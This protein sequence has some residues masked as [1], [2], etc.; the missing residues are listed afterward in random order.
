MRYTLLAITLLIT[1][2]ANKCSNKEGSTGDMADLKGMKWVF[3]RVG[4]QDVSVPAG[5]DAPWVQ[6]TPEGLSGFGG[7][8]R[9]MGGYQQEGERLK[10]T[11]L[12]STKRYCEATMDLENA[13]KGALDRTDSFRMKKDVLELVG[14]GQVLAT[15]KG[16]AV[17]PS[18]PS[19][20]EDY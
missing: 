3:Q 14:G 19:A 18:K 16:E 6:L 13:V 17:P 15:L 5:S 12:A 4:G 10:I 7:C 1:L 9:L 2:T 8:N 20:V 11:D